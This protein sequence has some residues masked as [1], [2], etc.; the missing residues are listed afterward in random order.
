MDETLGGNPACN[1]AA[2]AAAFSMTEL[3]WDSTFEIVLHLNAA[4]PDVDFKELTLQQINDW[5]V[6]LPQFSD[7]PALVND[8]F[9]TA[10]YQEW[11]EEANP[12]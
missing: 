8:D 12:L 6:A 2:V 4:H 9:L 1:R 3:Y 10:I 7:D 5:T 11:F